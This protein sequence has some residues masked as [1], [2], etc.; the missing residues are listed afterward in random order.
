[1]YDIAVENYNTDPS[2]PERKRHEIQENKLSLQNT[3]QSYLF[4]SYRSNNPKITH[5]Y[6]NMSYSG[7]PVW[8][9]FEV[10]NMGDFGKLLSC[11]TYDVRDAITRKLGLNISVDTNRAL[12]YKFI[13]CLKDL[14]NAIAHNDVVFDS[15]FKRFNSSK[16]MEEC[17]KQDVGLSYMNFDK[18]DDYIILVS[19]Y[20]KLL[21]VP[22][23][24]ITAFIES[25]ESIV[26]EY[27]KS[28]SEQVSGVVIHPDLNNRINILKKFIQHLKS[29]QKPGI[30]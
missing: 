1:M 15:R 17:I 21:E 14:R 20:L 22:K 12:I 26:D 19:Y 18:I 4:S 2:L 3:V 13:Y 7:V 5:F 10:L 9:L 16:A 6:N 8:A 23:T 27:K 24:E 30:I 29:T 11:L 28:V 25:F